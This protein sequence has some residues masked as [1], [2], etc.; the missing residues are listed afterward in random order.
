MSF[1]EQITCK[2]GAMFAAAVIEEHMDG[3]WNKNKKEYLE[4]GCTVSIVNNTK[5]NM[6][7]FKSCKCPKT[8]KQILEA[9]QLNLFQDDTTI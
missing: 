9:A 5:E 6:Q 4:G 1:I 7:Q 3:E 8:P 2:C